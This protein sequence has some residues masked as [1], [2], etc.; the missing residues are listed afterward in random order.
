MYIMPNMVD[1][2]LPVKGEWKSTAHRAVA[3]NIGLCKSNVTTRDALMEIVAAVQSVPLDRIETITFRELQDEFNCP[4][5]DLPP[6]EPVEQA[7]SVDWTMHSLQTEFTL[8]VRCTQFRI[9]ASAQSGCKLTPDDLIMFQ[10]VCDA[11][12]R[13]AAFILS[14]DKSGE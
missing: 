10:R 8:R 5:I 11:A 7:F 12:N 13:Q 9:R 1:I 3:Q 4:Y 14:D 2:G 6:E